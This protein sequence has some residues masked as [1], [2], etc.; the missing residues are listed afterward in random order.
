[1]FTSTRTAAALSSRFEVRS[2]TR[3]FA[4]M[5]VAQPTCISATSSGPRTW[6]SGGISAVAMSGGITSARYGTKYSF[7]APASRPIDAITKAACGSSGLSDATSIDW[8]YCMSAM[9]SSW[10]R[11]GP[12]AAPIADIASTALPRRSTNSS[13]SAERISLRIG[14][15]VS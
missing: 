4:S 6:Y 15:N 8:R 9:P 13:P 14:M 5:I 3:L 11:S 10:K 2:W 1:M 7:M 12:H